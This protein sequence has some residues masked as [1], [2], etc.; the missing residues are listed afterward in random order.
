MLIKVKLEFLDGK[1]LKKAIE[2]EL[3]TVVEAKLPL[4]PT[5]V[6]AEVIEAREALYET[7]Y[8]NAEAAVDF[9]K[10]RSYAIF[11]FDFEIKT[12]KLVGLS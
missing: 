12:A 9:V 2:R 4:T 11:D 10:E 7:L 8:E 5:C 3:I 1:A 6:V